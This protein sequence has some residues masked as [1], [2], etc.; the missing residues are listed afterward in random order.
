MSQSQLSC[1]VRNLWLPRF[2]H[3]LAAGM[4]VERIHTFFVDENNVTMAPSV[5]W[6]YAD[7]KA[8]A[9]KAL[10]WALPLA[11]LILFLSTLFALALRKTRR[12]RAEA[13]SAPVE[14]IP[15]LSERDRLVLEDE[16]DLLD[17]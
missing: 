4:T 5:P 10:S 2:R 1:T 11:V 7:L 15:V 17:A 12:N 8:H 14:V 9:D 16:M 6:S 13:R 3:M